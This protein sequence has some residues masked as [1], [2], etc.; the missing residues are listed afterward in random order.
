MILITG[1]LGFVGSQLVKHLNSK[2]I[3]NLVLVDTLQS[4]DWQT[5]AK[6]HFIDF[7]DFSIG[8]QEVYTSLKDYNFEAVFHIGADADVLNL[9]IQAMLHSNFDFTKQY[10]KLAKSS[11]CPFI[12]ASSSAIYG[13]SLAFD[14]K[15][16]SGSPHNAYAFSKACA[17]RFLDANKEELPA[18]YSFRF[19]NVFGP[20]ESHKGKN[21]SIPHRFA[22]FALETSEIELFDE[23]IRR[24]YVFVGD[25]CTVLLES[26][27]SGLKSGI[28]NLGSGSTIRHSDISE[29]VVNASSEI[30]RRTVKVS[31]I[32]M[33]ASLRD[34]F[35]FHTQAEG[36]EPFVANRTKGVKEKM[37]SYIDD[38][39][40]KDSARVN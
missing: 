11:H 18:M 34:R 39:L 29:M 32:A 17:D 2:G 5:L 30:L 40:I 9:N 35:Q 14:T 20:G 36:L 25:L 19:F 23:P 7:V 28:Y 13:N 8:L 33:P 4:K 6:Y 26:L 12:F 27:E 22:K 10:F 15:D 16:V 38:L 1:A 21:S 37:R 24:D 3:N 31:K